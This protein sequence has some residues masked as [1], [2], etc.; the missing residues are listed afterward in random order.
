M[1]ENTP[2]DVVKILISN[3]ADKIDQNVSKEDGE[4]FAVQNGLIFYEWSAKTGL[5]V[6]EVFDRV[7][8]CSNNLL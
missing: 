2:A 1:D 7:F 5:N 6:F 8:A 4:D 3:K